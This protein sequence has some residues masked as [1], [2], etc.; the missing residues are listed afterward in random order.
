MSEDSTPQD[1]VKDFFD[2]RY[3]AREFYENITMYVLSEHPVSINFTNETV[4]AEDSYVF[5]LIL[6]L[7]DDKKDSSSISLFNISFPNRN[8][9]SFNKSQPNE[10]WGK[11]NNVS[12]YTYKG[13]INTSNTNS[14]N[15]ILV[16]IDNDLIFIGQF[17]DTKININD[18]KVTKIRFIPTESSELLSHEAFLVTENRQVLHYKGPNSQAK[19]TSIHRFKKG[20]TDISIDPYNTQTCLVSHGTKKINLLDTRDSARTSFNLKESTSSIS[21]SP[22]IPFMF[23]TGSTGGIVGF[24]DSR[25]TQA[26]IFQIT[27]HDSI[28]SSVIWSPHQRDIVASSS[29]DAGIAL[30]SVTEAKEKRDGDPIAVFAHNGHLTPITSFDWCKDISWTLASVSQDNLLEVWS[31]APYQIDD[32]YYPK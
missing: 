32:Y 7:Y 27:A 6:G 18:D 1:T 4:C 23:S 29:D 16:S 10:N 9:I 17:S 26:P 21:F 25:Y 28:V 30:W 14:N 19:P 3:H 20:I 13:R 31:I 5:G 11:V 24:Y 12:K 15:D 2:W 8:S 22:H